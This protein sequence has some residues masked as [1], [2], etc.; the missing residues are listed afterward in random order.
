MGKKVFILNHGLATGGTDTFTINLSKGLKDRGYDVSVVMAVYPDSEPQPR[1]HIL[2]DA[3]IPLYKTSDLVGV[4]GILTHAIRLYRLL[5]QHK[6]DVFHAN[7]DLFNGINMLAAWLAGVPVRVC[8]SH[9]AQSQYETNTGNHLAANIYRSFMRWLCRIFANRYCGCS[10][11]AMDYLF[12]SSWKNNPKAKIIYNGIDLS[13]F[14]SAEDHKRDP[15][16]KNIVTVG[17]ISKTKNPDFI[18]RIVEKLSLLRHDFRMIWVGEGEL[19]EQTKAAILQKGLDG[20]I[21]MTGSRN[22][23]PSILGKCDVFILPSLFEGLGISLIEAQAAGL[24]S[25]ASDTVPRDV[26]CGMCD[27]LPINSADIWAEKINDYFN[28]GTEKAL[29]ALLLDRFDIDTMITEAEKVYSL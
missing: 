8:H 13:L 17:R 27:F 9:T 16:T 10:A 28:S 29:N 15:E 4:K 24:Y 7:M 1:E 18:I 12:K 6:P 23:I 26:D 2:R 22:D 25:I 3:G 5:R 11:M 20:L 21:N 14:K 19:Y